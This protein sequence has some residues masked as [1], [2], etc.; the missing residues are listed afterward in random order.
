MDWPLLSAHGTELPLAGRSFRLLPIAFSFRRPF[1]LSTRR[2]SFWRCSS[3]FSF[4]VMVGRISE[5][6]AEEME[7]DVIGL[8][9]EREVGREGRTIPC[10]L[11]LLGGFCLRNDGFCADFFYL[12]FQAA[13]TWP[14]LCRLVGLLCFIT[15][16]NVVRLTVMSLLPPTFYGLVQCSIK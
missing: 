15:T 6:G 9:W 3:S 13:A 2:R 8:E 16:Q 1:P 10:F 4:L 7:S 12:L 5:R 11:P 14:S